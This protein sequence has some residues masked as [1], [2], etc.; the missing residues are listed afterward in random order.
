MTQTQTL[1]LTVQSVLQI[2]TERLMT[3]TDT[4]QLEAQLLLGHVLGQ[5]RTWLLTWADTIVAPTDFDVFQQYIERRAAGEPLPYILGCWEFFGI[6]FAVS[7]ATLI[8]RPETELLVEAAL[9]YIS[10]Q[11]RDVTVVDVG[12]GTGCIGLTIAAHAANTRITLVDC[13]ADALEIAEENARSLNKFVALRQN[14]LL[15]GL[16]QFDV[17][18]SNPPYVAPCDMETL[19]VADYEPHLALDGGA[20]NGMEVITRL[21]PQVK[22]HLNPG[23]IFLMEFGA[24]QGQAVYALATEVFPAASVEIL[25][26]YA[27]LDRLLRISLP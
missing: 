10:R 1:A 13:S 26:D 8:P 5:S 2:G 17:I 27:G 25:Q 24:D 3:T 23:G 20:D 12:T 7:T 18:C 22:T 14:D 19:P 11:H 16:G 15:E 21:L 9:D 4:P 6:D